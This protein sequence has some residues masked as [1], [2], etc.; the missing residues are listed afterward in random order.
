MPNQNADTPYWRIHELRALYRESHEALD[1][2]ERPPAPQAAPVARPLA[3]HYAGTKRQPRPLSREAQERANAQLRESGATLG[4]VDAILAAQIGREEPLE[5][6]SWTTDS[7][8]P[9]TRPG[10]SD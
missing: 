3:A 6:R 1:A 7:E 10:G 9:G 2:L 5:P 8:V 4:T